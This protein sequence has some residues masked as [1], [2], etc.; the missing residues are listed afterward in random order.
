MPKPANVG[1]ILAGVAL[2]FTAYVLGASLASNLFPGSAHANRMEMHSDKV[3]ASI[4]IVVAALL[5]RRYL[6]RSFGLALTCLAA[7]EAA[8]FLIIIQFTGLMEF[9]L[10]DLR[11]NVGWLYA[12]TWNVVVAFLI[13]TTIG[14]LWDRRAANKS[15]QPTAAAPGS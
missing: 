3:G 14:H 15:R 7:T 13:G 2:L 11:F 4:G 12:L 6:L 5:L 10:F 9:T 1:R 8:A